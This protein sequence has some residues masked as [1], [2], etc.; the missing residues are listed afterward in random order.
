MK[1]SPLSLPFSSILFCALVFCFAYKRKTKKHHGTLGWSKLLTCDIILWKLQCQYNCK[2]MLWEMNRNKWCGSKEKLFCYAWIIIIIS[3][4]CN[5]F[6]SM[7]FVVLFFFWYVLLNEFYEENAW[8]W[9]LCGII[10]FF[11]IVPH[12]L[13]HSHFPFFLLCICVCVSY[14]FYIYHFSLSKA[15]AW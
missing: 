13:Y 9:N 10:F 8:W 12:I 5:Y 14:A 1:D 11:N 3:R 4:I 2:T 15:I 6:A 7:G